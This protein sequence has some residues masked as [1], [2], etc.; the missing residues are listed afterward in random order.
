MK[1][2]ALGFRAHSGW[3]ALVAL[4]LEKNQPQVLMRQRPKLVQ[5]FTYQFR[6]PY[7]TAEKLPME[8]AQEFVSQVESV[9][10]RLAEDAIRTIQ[11]DLRNEGYELTCFGLPVASARPLPRLEK[12]LL[13]HALVHTADGELF[14]RALIRA[15]E[16][17]HLA[18]LML[19]ERELVTVASQTLKIDKDNL[20]GRLAEFGKPVGPPWSQDEKFATMAAWLALLHDAKRQKH[21]SPGSHRS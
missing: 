6:Q 1:P 14:R 2:V 9:A 16:Q 17:C 11:G 3:T 13:S 19:A 15:G 7:H 10:T 21:R 18:G 8:R 20:L 12:I 4:S 5:E